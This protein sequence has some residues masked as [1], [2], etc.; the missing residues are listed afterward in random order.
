MITCHNLEKFIIETLES[1]DNQTLTDYEVIIVDDCSADNSY[2]IVKNYIEDKEN[3]SL[4]KTPMQ[5]GVAQSRNLC[6]E[7]CKGKYVAVLDG[8]DVWA[9]CKLEK[10]YEFMQ[11][12]TIDMC[13]SSYSFIN[14]ESKSLNYTYKT[15]GTAEYGTLLKENYIGCSTVVLSARLA[16]EFNMDPES[17][18]EDYSFWLNVLKQG[19]E[20]MGIIDPLVMYRLHHSSRSYN[21]VHA[22]K[23]RF[24]VLRKNEQIGLLKSLYLFAHYAIK[25]LRKFAHLWTS[26]LKQ[27]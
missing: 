11:K 1:V 26:L 8:D 17:K 20:A 16:K 15:K 23:A 3:W 10:Q 13:Y 7:L 9:T 6:F 19:Y 27:K 21:K 4:H 5:S 2:N 24:L 12:H 22:A 18:A 14:D 25:A